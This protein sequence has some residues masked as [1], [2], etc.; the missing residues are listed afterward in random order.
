ME[1]DKSFF[2]LFRIL[3]ILNNNGIDVTKIPFRITVKKVFCTLN[4]IHQEGIDINQI[5]V[6]NNLNGDFEIG[7]ELSRFKDRY[8][9][10]TLNRQIKLLAE[11]Y[12]VV[13]I[14]LEG[15]RQTVISPFYKGMI[16]ANLADL[17]SGKLSNREV[18]ER[19]NQKANQ[20]GEAPIKSVITIK[21]M[22]AM[23][24]AES[25]DKY[26][27]Y[28]LAGYQRKDDGITWIDRK[29]IVQQLLIE[30]YLPIFFRGELSLV[31]IAKKLS[32]DPRTLNQ[33]IQEYYADNEDVLNRYR[34]Q[35]DRNR[36]M[37][38]KEKKKCKAAKDEVGSFTVAPKDIFIALS[39]EEQDEH[40]VMKIRKIR[41][42]EKTSDIDNDDSYVLSEIYAR[43]ALERIKQYFRSKNDPEEEI[44]YFSEKDIRLI[45]FCCPN[46]TGRTNETL[47]KKFKVLTSFYDWEDI[48]GMIKTFPGILSYSTERIKSQLNILSSEGLLNYLVSIPVG[49][50]LSPETMYALIKLA[51][52]ENSDLSTV[53]WHSIFMSNSNLKNKHGTTYDRIRVA[54]PLPSEMKVLKTEKDEGGTYTVEG[55]ELGIRGT[56]ASPKMKDEADSVMS[57]VI[58]KERQ[59]NVILEGEK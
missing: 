56:S 19:I 54:Y 49:F 55:Q 16:D 39:A 24:L 6:K 21:K 58:P 46:L 40:L 44:E 32:V 5:L 30:K 38:P 45:V 31:E 29:P 59:I 17:I 42:K 27:K 4:M 28:I 41:F 26:E 57:S 50:R 22:V 34:E 3:E 52:K 43:N 15:I 18:M 36:R 20:C 23:I 2:E 10:G 1:E 12:S 7:K 13:S 33:I 8:A 14:V 35:V 47:D 53:K 25:P 9:N 51:Q 37:S 48:S 11:K